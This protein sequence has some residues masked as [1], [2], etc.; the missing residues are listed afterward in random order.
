M[1]SFPIPAFLQNCTEDDIFQGMIASLP[2]NL[3]VSEGSHAWNFL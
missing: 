1:K 3:D 2:A